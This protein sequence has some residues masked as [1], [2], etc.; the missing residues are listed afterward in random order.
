M[1]IR[2]RIRGGV[3]YE[4]QDTKGGAIGKPVEASF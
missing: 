1:K 2:T 4:Q 3:H